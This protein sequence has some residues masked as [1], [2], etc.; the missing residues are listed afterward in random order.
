[1]N[2]STE[3]AQLFF[4][5]FL[6]ILAYTNRQL[7]LVPNVSKPTD[8]RDLGVEQSANQPVASSANTAMRL[9]STR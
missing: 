6:A 7:N 9:L 4:K 5:L 1:M 3:D 8:M 2:L